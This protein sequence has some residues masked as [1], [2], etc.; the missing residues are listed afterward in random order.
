MRDVATA[1]GTRPL[2]H[3]DAVA[4]AAAHH[5]VFRAPGN[6]DPDALAPITPADLAA[7]VTDPKV[8]DHAV[9]F[10]CV[11]AT[12]DAT[13]DAEKIA[14]VAKYATALER[15]PDEVHQLTEAA[16]GKLQ[17]VVA[18]MAR[19]NLL[20]VT[21]HEVGGDWNKWFTPYGDAP[22]PDLSARYAALERL[23]A[24]TFGRAF[25]DFYTTN[26]FPFP[27]ERASFNERFATP[28][29]T[30]HLL[31][32]YSTS[33]QGELLVSTFTAGMH[34]HEPVSGHILPVIFS[35][36]IGVHIVDIAGDFKGALDPEKFWAA[37][38]R[39]SALVVDVFDDAWDF[40]S[41]VERPLD[42]LREAYE[43]PPLLPALAADDRTPSWYHPTA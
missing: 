10:L 23:P 2:T 22:E 9:S 12:V 8:R 32:G 20:S 28:H 26:G 38:T 24:G 40:W 19:R 41:H 14:V 34:P 37:W 6:I 30:S 11:M 3:A 7:S 4:V 16:A 18:D 25:A 33:P 15:H 39:G 17:E 35:W 43:V 27:G 42:E 5:Y 1:D 36:H 29:D 21:G 31:S 13:I